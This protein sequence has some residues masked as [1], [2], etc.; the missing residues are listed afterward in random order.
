MSEELNMASL[1]EGEQIKMS[2]E[3]NA[4]LRELYMRLGEEY[5]KGAFEDPLPQ[6]LPI[7][8]K[9]TALFGKY[10]VAS[11]KCRN[12]GSEIEDDARFCQ[13]C[14]TPVEEMNIAEEKQE[15]G[16]CSNCGNPLRPGAKFCGS[17]GAPVR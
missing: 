16:F 6:L 15:A 17:C 5:Y 4:T 7:F 9:I 14:G 1:E 3:D 13:V 10:A 11:K 8:D 2:D 12:C